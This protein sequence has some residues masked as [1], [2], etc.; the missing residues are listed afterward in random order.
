M[1]GFD[2]IHGSALY[3]RMSVSRAKRSLYLYQLFPLLRLLTQ[4]RHNEFLQSLQ[5]KYNV[6][7]S[8][9]VIVS[10]ESLSASPELDFK[11]GTDQVSALVEN[12]SLNSWGFVAEPQL[13]L[14]EDLWI[15]RT[16]P[17]RLFAVNTICEPRFWTRSSFISNFLKSLNDST[18]RR[19]ISVVSERC[20]LEHTSRG[21]NFCFQRVIIFLGC[22]LVLLGDLLHG[23]FCYFWLDEP[24][25]FE[26]MDVHPAF[27]DAEYVNDG[28]LMTEGDDGNNKNA[29]SVITM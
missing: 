14:K 22:L 7:G 29:A 11:L 12:L 2:E 5:A 9:V 21:A 28:S 15:S 23:T 20:H 25:G 27:G 13:P 1:V 6:N 26:R 19:E 18:V 17:R 4:R 3:L 10:H 16:E 24:R 8:N